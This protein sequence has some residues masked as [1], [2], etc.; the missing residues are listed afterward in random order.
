MS[1]FNRKEKKYQHIRW[2]NIVMVWLWSF[3]YTII[4]ELDGVKNPN[5]VPVLVTFF[6]VRYFMRKKYKE[7]PDFTNKI[8]HTLK[9]WGIVIAVKM[10]LGTLFALIMFIK[11]PILMDV[12]YK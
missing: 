8:L 10:L 3:G 6:I 2:T 7:N 12:Y 9:T 5:V 11:Y 4:Q 1:D